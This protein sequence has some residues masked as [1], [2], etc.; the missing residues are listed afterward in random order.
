MADV[1]SLNH[2]EKVFLAGCIRSVMMADGSIENEELED[3]DK[4]LQNLKFKDYE[5]CLVEFEESV[6]DEESFYEYARRIK[7]KKAQEIILSTIYELGLHEGVP[8]SEEETI[9]NN[10]S[11]IWGSV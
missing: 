10:L 4:I 6:E 1:S 2:D 8:D 11:K 9:F 5:E 7:D 3:L